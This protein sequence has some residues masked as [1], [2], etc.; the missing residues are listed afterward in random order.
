VEKAEIAVDVKGLLER[1]L[2]SLFSM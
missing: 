1:L 2:P